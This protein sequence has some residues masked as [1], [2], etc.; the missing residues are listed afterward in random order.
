[1]KA[2]HKT[3]VTMVVGGGKELDGSAVSLSQEVRHFLGR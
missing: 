3:V 1:M 2:F